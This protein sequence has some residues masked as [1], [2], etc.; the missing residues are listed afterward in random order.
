MYKLKMKIGNM[1]HTKS[2]L[3]NNFSALCQFVKKYSLYLNEFF[4]QRAKEFMDNYMRIVLGFEHY[5]G[6][7]KFSLRRGLFHLHILGIAK[8]KAY[9]HNFH[10]AKTDEE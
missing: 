6:S 2:L 1:Q 10:W 7:V 3:E 5:W 4:M 9:L 8:D